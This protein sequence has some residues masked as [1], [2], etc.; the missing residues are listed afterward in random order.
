MCSGRGLWGVKIED[1]EY[2]TEYRNTERESREGLQ[3]SAPVLIQSV[4]SLSSKSSLSLPDE[5]CLRCAADNIILGISLHDMMCWH[6]HCSLSLC[7]CHSPSLAISF[8]SPSLCL[9]LF[10]LFSLSS[11]LPNCGPST[12]RLLHLPT[13]SCRNRSVCKVR[14]NCIPPYS[15]ESLYPLRREIMHSRFLSRNNP[16]ILS[17]PIAPTPRHP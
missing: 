7:L 6:I 10:S 15:H 9:F 17:S 16:S 5:G 2:R 4:F 13:I 11:L 1:T 8:L 14:G 12:T 3:M